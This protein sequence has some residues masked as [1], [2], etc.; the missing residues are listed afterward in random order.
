MSTALAQY[1]GSGGE[2]MQW[3]QPEEVLAEA[4]TAA[5]ALVKVI[6]MKKNKVVFNGE[7]YL[8][9]E[10]WQTVAKFYGC[11]AKVI[12][13]KY[14]EYGEAHGF[15][16]EAVVLDR[17]QSEIGRAESMCLSDEENWGMIPKYEWKDVL[18]AQGKKIWDQNLRS[19]KGG[20]KATKVQLG[21]IGG[22]CTST[23]CSL[24]I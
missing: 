21:L 10:D 18:D 6:E 15:E 24:R 19:G 22:T 5:T 7:T 2:L 4:K 12:S 11:T 20:Y 3:R 9:F 8:E 13:T 1:A 16:S 14:V 17:N 23:N